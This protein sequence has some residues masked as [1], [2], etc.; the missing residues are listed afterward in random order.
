MVLDAGVQWVQYREKY[1]PRREIYLMAKRLRKITSQYGAFFVVNDHPDIAVATGADGVHLGQ[2]D[3]PIELA[4]KVVAEMAI[5]I[6]THNLSEALQAQASGADY[7]GFG[8]VF[9]TT[10]KENALSPRGLQALRQ[11][12]TAVQIPVVAIGGIKK[13]NLV[14]VFQ[15]GASAV[16]VASG[17]LLAEDP[18]KQAR[19]FVK[20]VKEVI[21]P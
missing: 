21:S 20:I 15:H 16:A 7:I 6:S 12:A 18:Q 5:G 3:L 19:D 4:R 1:L 17:I 2:E 13:E 8:P 11:V 9:G 14:E 10:T